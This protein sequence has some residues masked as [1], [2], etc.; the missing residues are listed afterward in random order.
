MSVARESA[1][2]DRV[3]RNAGI[4]GR[5]IRELPGMAALADPD[6]RVPD[7]LRR[8]SRQLAT[9]LTNDDVVGVHLAG[10]ALHPGRAAFALAAAGAEI[11]Q[12]RRPT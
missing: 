6:L 9:G 2:P 11:T 5:S 1:L 7:A 4:R 3:G 12:E 8:G 10:T